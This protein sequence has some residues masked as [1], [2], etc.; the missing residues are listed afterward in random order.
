MC[1]SMKATVY[2]F[3]VPTAVGTFFASRVKVEWVLRSP[4]LSRPV[5]DTPA[6]SAL[7]ALE[8]ANGYEALFLVARFTQSEG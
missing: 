7:L 8:T 6:A 4:C 2:G 3:A 1:A 5:A